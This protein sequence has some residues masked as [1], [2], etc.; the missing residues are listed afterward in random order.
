MAAAAYALALNELLANEDTHLNLGPLSVC[1]WAKA[2]P[3]AARQFNLLLSKAHPDQVHEFLRGPFAGVEREVLKR[4]RLYTVA[5]SGNAGRVVVQHWIDQTL[6]EAVRHFAQWWADLEI[7]PVVALTAEM[8]QKKAQAN[9]PTEPSAWP[10]AIGN[11]ARVS[12]RRSKEQKDEKLVSERVVQLYRAALEGTAPPVTLLKPILDEFQSAL[13]KNDDSDAK[14]RTYPFS[15]SRFA[16]IKLILVRLERSRWEARSRNDTPSTKEI[17]FMPTYE[18]A[19]TADP[20]YN[21]GR[22]LA[23]FEALQDKYHEYEKKSAGV[24]ERYYGTASSAPAAAF[25]L[26][27][28][29]ARHHVS[30]VRR[31]DE[32]AAGAIDRRMGEI[33]VKFQP[34]GPGQPP[35]LPRVLNLEEQGR[36][37]LGFYQQR[38]FNSAAVRVH[39][40]LKKARET[41]DNAAQQ[42]SLVAQARELA[43]QFRTPELLDAVNR[44]DPNEKTKD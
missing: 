16:L 22:L 18:L 27:C 7:V 26:L 11:L 25:P 37:A 17:G 3:Q 41:K 23:V 8:K 1:F 30:K 39:G 4:D 35:R 33:L 12:L 38:A 19:E 9:P 40:L 43:E 24:V 32:N 5:L 15:S 14:K 29:L 42:D 13:V 2:V 34:A 44:L 10:L 36:F 20:A 21:L 31:D 6:D 28:R